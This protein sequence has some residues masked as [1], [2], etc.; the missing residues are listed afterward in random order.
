MLIFLNNECLI[1]Q[2]F[3]VSYKFFIKMYGK[4][5]PR[6]RCPKPAIIL[7]IPLKSQTYRLL[8]NVDYLLF[9]ENTKINQ[10]KQHPNQLNTSK[11]QQ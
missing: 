2:I 9:G 1:E 11:R 4:T 5:T 6:L 3:R 8:S 10:H 7:H